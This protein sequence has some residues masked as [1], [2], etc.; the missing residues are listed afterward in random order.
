MRTC[1]ASSGPCREYTL[2]A[3][4]AGKKDKLIGATCRQPVGSWQLAGS[5]L[6][7]HSTVSCLQASPMAARFD[8]TLTA[9][10]E[11]P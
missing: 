8:I 5:Q 10:E 11:S 6:K 1:G 3:V 4:V 7:H 2:D 9:N